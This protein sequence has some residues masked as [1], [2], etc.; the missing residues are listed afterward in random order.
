M[1]GDSLVYQIS[2]NRKADMAITKSVPSVKADA[3]TR[4]FQVNCEHI[5]WAV[6]DSGIQGDHPSFQDAEGTPRVLA[7]FDFSRYRKIVNLD[8]LRIFGAG[9][10]QQKQ[11]AIL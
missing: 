9:G 11:D 10:N 8:N 3:A 2:L 1:K 4:L 6:I 7:S 5:A